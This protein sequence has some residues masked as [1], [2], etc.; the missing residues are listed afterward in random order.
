MKASLVFIIFIIT[1]DIYGLSSSLV[2]SQ[3]ESCSSNQNLNGSV[4][5]DTTSLHCLAV[6]DSQ[7]FLLRVS[8]PFI[9]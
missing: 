2:N 4:P 8:A 1:I 5:F 6:W 9:N 3:A 7:G